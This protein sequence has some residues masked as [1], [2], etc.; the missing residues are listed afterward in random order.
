MYFSDIEATDFC[1][2]LLHDDDDN[3][4]DLCRSFWFSDFTTSMHWWL[5]SQLEQLHSF[6][7]NRTC[8][9]AYFNVHQRAVV[10]RQSDNCL[11]GQEPY[12]FS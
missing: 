9:D 5:L 6:S 1:F 2:R 7:W 3:A 11:G 8:R 10:W 4:G 12:G